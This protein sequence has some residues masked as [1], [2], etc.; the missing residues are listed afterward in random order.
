MVQNFDIPVSA[1]ALSVES[2]HP[3]VVVPHPTLS[4]EGPTSFAMEE[5]VPKSSGQ[6]SYG[7]TMIGCIM[8]PIDLTTRSR[9]FLV[10]KH[11]ELCLDSVLFVVSL[12]SYDGRMRILHAYLDVFPAPKCGGGFRID[13]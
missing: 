2:I 1:M 8:P 7:A 3:S 6:F 5:F 13:E 4:P 10:E 12:D 11:V 9:L